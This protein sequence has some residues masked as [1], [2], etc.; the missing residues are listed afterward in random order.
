MVSS[1]T[2]LNRAKIA[3]VTFPKG[4]ITV[5]QAKAM[6]LSIA[7]S[8]VGY[9]PGSSVSIYGNG[10]RWATHGTWHWQ[11]YWC[12]RGI[13][14]VFDFCFGAEAA[15]AGI[16]H[17][18][19]VPMP[20]GWAATW[21][22]RDWL[23]SKGLWVGLERAQPGDISMQSWG[24]TSKPTDHVELVTGKWN[25]SYYNCIGFNTVSQGTSGVTSGGG[26]WRVRR[27]RTALVAIYRPD[28]DALVRTYNA[29]VAAE[30]ITEGIQDLTQYAEALAAFG[31]PATP[32][33]VGGYQ[34]WR[35]GPPHNLVVDRIFGP[36]TKAALEA[37]V[38]TL[39]DLAADL[40][41]IK[42][43]VVHTLSDDDKTKMGTGRSPL[44]V[45]QLAIMDGARN[46]TTM[47][48]A[49]ATN[50]ALAQVLDA[51]AEVLGH[52]VD[53]RA[54]LALLS[55][56]IT[57]AVAE[58]VS[59]L[60]VDVDAQAIANVTADVLAARLTTPQEA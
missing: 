60:H 39:E 43:A 12:A 56:D 57:E 50:A 15:K 44:T 25:G 13:S 41:A 2:A 11:G 4:K 32:A 7:D 59:Q 6:V 58:A 22:W 33:G 51:L 36:K 38:N 9:N 34:E 30:D 8:Q 52:Q 55:D 27:N 35:S 5:A 28:W 45:S 26:V 20:A 14:W 37:D 23:R 10:T 21:L 47:S 48:R 46:L 24:R 16:G 53:V 18:P 40:A 42:T 17:Q 54:M 49:S 29:T 31:F 19:H 3:K 1:T